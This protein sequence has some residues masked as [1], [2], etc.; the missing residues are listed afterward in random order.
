MYKDLSWQ[1]KELTLLFP[2]EQRGLVYDWIHKLPRDL[3][4]FSDN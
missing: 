4:M 1:E 2:K 3:S